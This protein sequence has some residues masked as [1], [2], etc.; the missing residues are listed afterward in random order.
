MHLRHAPELG[1][2]GKASKNGLSLIVPSSGDNGG[3]SSQ[4]PFSMLVGASFS[5]SKPSRSSELKILGVHKGQE[6]CDD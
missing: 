2:R 4:Q 3:I 5:F 1:R 6:K